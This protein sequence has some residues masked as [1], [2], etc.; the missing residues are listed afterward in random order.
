[1]TETQISEAKWKNLSGNKRGYV[2]GSK[3]GNLAIFQSGYIAQVTE[4][5]PSFL[6]V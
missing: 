3:Y 5:H 4:D 2:E 1:M 6:F